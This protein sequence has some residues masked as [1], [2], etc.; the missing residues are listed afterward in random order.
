MEIQDELCGKCWTGDEA[1][2]P[3]ILSLPLAHS[4]V[5]RFFGG[6]YLQGE[7]VGGGCRALLTCYHEGCHNSNRQG[8]SVVNEDLRE[9]VNKSQK[10]GEECDVI[11]A[12]G[13]HKEPGYH[14]AHS[15]GMSVAKWKTG[16]T[17]MLPCLSSLWLHRG[18]LVSCL[19][20]CKSSLSNS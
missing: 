4:P 8:C 6:S 2:P 14:I 3:T 13:E 19:V 17:C 11:E 18:H 20:R 15:V 1:F 7:F 12:V 9:E 16:Q 5:E 10:E